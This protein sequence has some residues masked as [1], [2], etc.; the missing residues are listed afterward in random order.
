MQFVKTHLKLFCV[1]VAIAA[2]IVVFLIGYSLFRS[3][4]NLPSLS[5]VTMIEMGTLTTTNEDEINV[6]MSALLEAHRVSIFA[7]NEQPFSQNILQ[8]YLYGIVNGEEVMMRRMYLYT[9]GGNEN[10]WNSYRGVYRI[11]QENSIKIRNL[12]VR[13]ADFTFEN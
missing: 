10:I 8:I 2:L 12:Y 1:L 9:D 6:I 4:I 11:S 13:M 5:D 7:M 3:T